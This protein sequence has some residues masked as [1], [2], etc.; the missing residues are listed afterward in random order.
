M[1][2]SGRERDGFAEKYAK[3][4]PLCARARARLNDHVERS[5]LRT[6]HC[7]CH[8]CATHN[9]IHTSIIPPETL[10]H[11]LSSVSA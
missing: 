9:L 1:T 4:P 6:M 7:Y 3:T 10:P 11:L 8:N 5:Q 2:M